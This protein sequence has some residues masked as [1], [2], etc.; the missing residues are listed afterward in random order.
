MVIVLYS[1]TD[2]FCFEQLF[3]YSLLGS[4]S[5]YRTTRTIC[6]ISFIFRSIRKLEEFIGIWF[7]TLFQIKESLLSLYPLCFTHQAYWLYS[8]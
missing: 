3:V 2:F 7:Y 8:Q 6:I 1:T 4:Q 5:P